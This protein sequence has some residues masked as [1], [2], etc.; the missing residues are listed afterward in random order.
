VGL[1]CVVIA[2]IPLA[3][4]L[5]EVVRNGLPTINL[6]FLTSEATF[7]LQSAGGIGPAI[8]GTFLLI[9]LGSIIA[10][11]LGL[12]AGIY[13]VEFGDNSFGKTVR[14]LNDV[15]AEFPSIVVGIIVASVLV[16]ATHHFSLI[17]GATALA[18]IMVPV[19]TR[20]TEESIKIVPTSIR[21]A[22]MALGIRRWRATLSVVLITAKRGVV[23]GILL[24]IARIAGETA[25]LVLTILGS[26]FF[27][28]GIDQ[29]MAALPLVIFKNSFLP[30]AYA[31]QQAWGAAL[32]LILIVLSLNIGVRLATRGQYAASRSRI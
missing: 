12:L 8:Q 17:A 29:P 15:L 14:F 6:E 32:I 31:R 24:S 30:S 2:I 25:P 3:S 1:L 9:G 26:Q 21:D 11:P 22:A 7:S 16:V 19:V 10:I 18:I 20:T 28:S 5:V 4:I 27:F 23:T 13:L